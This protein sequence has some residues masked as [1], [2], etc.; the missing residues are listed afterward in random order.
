MEYVI[1]SYKTRYEQATINEALKYLKTCKVVG[2]D[3]ET[4][5]LDPHSSKVI[6][7]QIGDLVNQ[8]VI[9]TRCVDPSPLKEILENPR[10]KKV[11]VNLGF[12][13]KMVKSSFGWDCEGL[14]DLMLNEM[15][16]K[17]GYTIGDLKRLKYKAFYSM[18]ALSERYL[19]MD[20][21][22][23]RLSLFPDIVTFKDV[24]KEFVT[25]EGPFTD[26]QISYGIGDVKIPL[27]IKKYQDELI[28]NEVL[29][30]T[31]ALENEYL[32][33][34]SEMEYNGFYCDPDKWEETYKYYTRKKQWALFLLH[35]HLSD[36]GIYSEY[37]GINWNSHPQVKK[38][39]KSLGIDISV[40]DKRKSRELGIEVWKETLEKKYIKKRKKLHPIV[41]LFLD[42]KKYAKYTSTYGHKFLEHI[43]PV[44]GRIHPSFWQIVKTGRSSC[45]KPN[46]QNIPRGERFRSCFI[47]PPGK[48]LVTGD[49]SGQ[50]LRII[51]D[52]AQE[53]KMIEAFKN[54]QDVHALTASIL[55]HKPINAEDHPQERYNGKVLN[56]SLIY[57]ASA[58]TLSENMEIP[59]S[60]ASQL[61]KNYFRGYK[62]IDLFLKGVRARA[63]RDG[64]IKIDNIVGRKHWHIDQAEYDLLKTFINRWKANGWEVPSK[65]NSRFWSC[66]G[67][68]ERDAGN[69]SVQGV[70]ASMTKLALIYMHKWIKSTNL[71][72][73]LVNT[74]HD[75]IVVETEECYGE[76]VRENLKRCMEAAGAA[77]CNIPIICNPKISK[78]WSH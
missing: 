30:Q 23:N 35:C 26:K 25:H 69:Y 21:S 70:A 62:A 44:T 38:L 51:A 73:K 34:K 74:I 56:F 29:E 13:Y 3:T 36:L 47:A 8:Y 33:P 66:K 12:D 52:R 19:H 17:G 68:I 9:D 48:V 15:V 72:I 61:L 18:A 54:G 43:N 77:F 20:L 57:G 78:V 14:E 75:E 39:F 58:K 5:G 60:E 22:P 46:L 45:T 7:L 32:I 6:M 37:K 71:D 1:A 2:F 55:Y 40:I 11:G 31:C 41:G 16:V 50:E 24:G 65:I 27:L 4:T 76:L 53:K 67:K 42:Y 10:I 59:L 28:S 63:L 64:V 49:Y